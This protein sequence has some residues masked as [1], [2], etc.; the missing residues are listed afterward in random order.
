MKFSDIFTEEDRRLWTPHT[1]AKGETIFMEGQ[2]CEHVGFLERG[3]LLIAS[4]SF[5]G[6]ELICS[7]ILP[8]GFFGNNLLFSADR[9]YK[10]NVIARAKS[11]LWL[12]NEKNLIILLARNQRFLRFF[13]GPQAEK[14]KV[15][16]ARIKLLSFVKLKERLLFALF[17]NNG[18]LPFHT[19]AS[20]A[21]ELGAERE[22]LS[23]LLSRMDE[24][25]EIERLPDRIIKK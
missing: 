7:T 12:I 4:S 21:A 25:G 20:L 15:L 13:L 22:T 2:V 1:F 23:R 17:A 14:M 6:N 24:D 3:E 11:R 19:V 10:G 18:V 9:R 5:E 16:S 8:G